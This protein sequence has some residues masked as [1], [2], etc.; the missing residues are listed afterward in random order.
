MTLDHFAEQGLESAMVFIVFINALPLIAPAD[1]V[2]Q[3]TGEVYAGSSRHEPLLAHDCPISK[4][5]KPDTYHS[6]PTIH[7][8]PL[9]VDIAIRT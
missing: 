8:R 2:V 7:L 6:P 4:L 5:Q 1:D 3:G 9:F